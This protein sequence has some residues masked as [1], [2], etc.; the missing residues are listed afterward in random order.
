LEV[1]YSQSPICSYFPQSDNLHL[2]FVSF[3]PVVWDVWEVCTVTLSFYQVA[4][5]RHVEL[6]PGRDTPPP[7]AVR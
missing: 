4:A 3:I 5:Q 2:S 1:P 6:M 7:P